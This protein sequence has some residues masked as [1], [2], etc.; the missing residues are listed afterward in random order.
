MLQNGCECRKGKLEEWKQNWD[1][2]FMDKEGKKEERS[3]MASRTQTQT[4]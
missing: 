4:S 1:K 2:V 3:K